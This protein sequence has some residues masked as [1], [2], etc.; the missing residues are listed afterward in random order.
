MIQAAILTISDSSHQ[1]L[2]ADQSGPAL[3]EVV[4]KLG[5]QVTCTEVIPDDRYQIAQRLREL[6]DS[7]A[8]MVIFTTGGTGVAP[9]DVTPEALG[10]VI[11]REIPGLGEQMRAEGLRYTPLA[12]LSRS[13][14]GTRGKTLIVAL[15]GSP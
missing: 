8:A 4:E 3:R 10:D 13:L 7:E 12:V 6:A 11:D 9:R 14:G 2:R 15:P 1:G 5:W